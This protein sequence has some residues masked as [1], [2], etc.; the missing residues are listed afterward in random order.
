MHL[1]MFATSLEFGT[2]P[3]I[4]HIFTE[5]AVMFI[6]ISSH[7][8]YGETYTVYIGIVVIDLYWPYPLSFRIKHFQIYF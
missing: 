8:N 5:F 4:T 1:L 3:K 6:E 7:L 2:L